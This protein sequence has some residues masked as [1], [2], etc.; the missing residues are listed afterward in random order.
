MFN[1]KVRFFDVKT[2]ELAE[3]LRALITRV[4]LAGAAV[5][6]YCLAKF[7]RKFSANSLRGGIRHIL[8]TR[9]CL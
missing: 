9:I 8:D 7:F 6:F 4:S 1:C 5:Q 2:V 3:Y